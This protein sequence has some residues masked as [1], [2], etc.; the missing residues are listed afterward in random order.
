MATRQETLS[1]SRVT[2]F[3]VFWPPDVPHHALHW[4]KAISLT[5]FQHSQTLKHIQLG[6]Q[7]SFH[8]SDSLPIRDE[9]SYVPCTC[10]ILP[11]QEF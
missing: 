8:V 9:L 3:A 2:L 6:R 1:D 4:E 5:I 7:A 10:T 11:T